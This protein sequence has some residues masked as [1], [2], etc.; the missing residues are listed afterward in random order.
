MDV[1]LNSLLILDKVGK[2]VEVTEVCAKLMTDIIGTTAFGIRFNSLV[3]PDAEF[4]KYGRAM[5]KTSY[6]RY[7]QMVAIFF[8]PALRWIT[9]AQFF[10]ENGT[11]FFRTTFW[12]VINERKKTG[13][14]R[15][16]LIDTLI[17]LMKDQDDDKSDS[18][19]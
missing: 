5:F 12:D 11:Q 8:V 1:V 17:G 18:F 14:K 19:S 9:N 10:G 6:K 7:L 15:Q 16:D 4:R 3:D 13:I 2:P